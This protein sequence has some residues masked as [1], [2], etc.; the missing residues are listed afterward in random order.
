MTPQKLLQEI[1]AGKFA[2]AY[3][4]WGTE[5]HRMMEAQKYL[6]GQFL[7]NLQLSTNY[8]RIDG[9]R[10]PCP[11]L[12]AELSVYPML[13]ER[14]VFVVSDIQHYKP[15]D[16]ERILKLLNPPDPNRVMVFVTPSSRK[17]K[18]TSAFYKT[19]S[20]VATDV[21]FNKL[22]VE[23]TC[24]QILGRLNKAQVKI[25]SKALQLL[26][27]LIAGDHGALVSEVNK[28]INYRQPGEKITEKDIRT[29]TAGY[30]VFQVYEIGNYIVSAKAGEILKC[31]RTML[32]E[33]NTATGIIFFI[34][35]HFLSLYLVKNGKPVPDPRRAWLANQYRQQARGFTNPQLEQMMIQIAATDAQ[36]RSLSSH[37]KPDIILESLALQLARPQ[38]GN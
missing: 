24:N 30:Q 35:Q 29:L 6:A 11:E 23:E 26:A 34:A 13:G 4:F 3:Y 15:H 20:G 5:D 31:L 36:L 2:P 8:R 28:L 25:E 32:A 7:P 16:L 27:E 22:S 10:T 37:T 12:L 1:Q 38:G 18:K 33:G 19:I 14:Q 21:E 17:P 9:R